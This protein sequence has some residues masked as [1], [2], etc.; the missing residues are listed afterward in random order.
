MGPP[1][2]S[3]H[4]AH[5]KRMSGTCQAHARRMSGACQAVLQMP[6]SCMHHTCMLVCYPGL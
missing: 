1:A 2:Y 5:A 4:Q 6:A 3:M